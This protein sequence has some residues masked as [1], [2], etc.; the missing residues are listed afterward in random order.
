MNSPYDDAGSVSREKLPHLESVV[1]V[2]GIPVERLS[3]IRRL[4]NLFT[5][6]M[7]VRYLLVGLCNTLIGY[8]SFVIALHLLSEI[9]ATRH[10]YVA[11]PLASVISTPVSITIAY[12]GYKFFVFR[13]HGNYLR[14][15]LKCFAVYGTGMLPGLFALGALTRL[16]QGTIR[17]HAPMLHA[18][19]G[20]T[21]SHLSGPLL[22]GVHATAASKN[23]AGNLA[24]AIV[25]GFTT[26]YSFVGHR[27][28]TFKP[29]TAKS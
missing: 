4:M 5:G 8:C 25:M 19:L 29:V 28:V 20:V 22:H 15:W 9:I 27:K 6:G 11:A 12:F 24:G 7:F 18:M 1:P 2:A 21:E 13:T 23:I 16:F 26:I 10:L 14:E 3:G 17:T